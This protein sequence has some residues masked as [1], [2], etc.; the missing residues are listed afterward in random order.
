MY[1]TISELITNK[2]EEAGIEVTSGIVQ[3]A[4]DGDDKHGLGKLF[5]PS[6]KVTVGEFTI[7]GQAF[8]SDE[9]ADQIKDFIPSGDEQVWPEHCKI[10]KE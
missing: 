6:A 7:V 3:I 1:G 2:L 10:G 5:I 4:T 8:L 9:L